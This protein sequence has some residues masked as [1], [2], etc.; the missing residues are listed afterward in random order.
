MR[1]VLL[2]GTMTAI[3]AMIFAA[4]AGAQ[5][6]SSRGIQ[7]LSVSYDECINRSRRA[8][9]AEGY[10]LQIQGGEN[11]DY[12]VVGQKSIH[13]AVIACDAAPDGKFWANIFVASV[14]TDGGVPG[15]ERVKLQGRMAG[16]GGGTPESIDWGKQPNS[17]E[18]RQVGYRYTF[19]CRPGGPTGGR[20]WGTD[21]YTDDSSICLAA[22]H[23][24]LI[25][26]AAG[27]TVTIE[28]R[29]G[30]PSY[31]GTTRYGVT[32]N[33]YGSWGGS[34]AFVR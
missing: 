14:S 24:G 21:L 11:G 12:H 13:T 8:L 10:T 20:L 30:A 16:G 32:S 33:G 4:W 34:F 22:V 31:A 26:A 28:M 5:P 1:N 15:A 17:I 3:V 9:D 7:N 27:G 23:S 29:P 19:T 2:N 25:T 6:A 18:G